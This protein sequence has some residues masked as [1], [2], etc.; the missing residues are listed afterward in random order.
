MV[1]IETEE[2]RFTETFERSEVE[3]WDELEALRRKSEAPCDRHDSG[4]CT[5]GKSSP[6]KDSREDTAESASA[7]NRE[8]KEN[9]PPIRD[10][11]ENKGGN[12]PRRESRENKPGNPPRRDNKGDNAP[13]RDN[14]NQRKD[15]RRN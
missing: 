13:R 9:T 1:F 7:E 12:P 2:K 4:G 10:N 6:L 3:P 14:P 8:N 11:R 15:N 5:C